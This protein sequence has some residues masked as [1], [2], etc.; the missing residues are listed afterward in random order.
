MVRDPRSP[1]GLVGPERIGFSFPKEKILCT[2]VCANVET[3]VLAGS[4]CYIKKAISS[5]LTLHTHFL[6]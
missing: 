6:N 2:A 4:H 5:F 3:L 1:E